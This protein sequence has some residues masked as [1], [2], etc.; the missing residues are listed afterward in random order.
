[1]TRCS[2]LSIPFTNSSQLLNTLQTEVLRISVEEKQTVVN[3]PQDQQATDVKSPK[4]NKRSKPAV[5]T[6]G[7]SSA[8]P[9]PAA[10]KREKTQ[11]KDG[12]TEIAY[13]LIAPL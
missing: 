13:A 10:R 11:Q 2:S 1:M 12:K 3:V 4:A 6:T 5:A 7:A 8:S 9:A